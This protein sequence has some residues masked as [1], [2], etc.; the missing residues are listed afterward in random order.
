MR[1]SALTE[2]TNPLWRHTMHF[3]FGYITSRLQGDVTPLLFRPVLIAAVAALAACGSDEDSGRPV[4]IVKT[5]LTCDDSL[6]TGFT[7]DA[8]TTVVAVKSF[9]KGDALLLSGAATPRTP[10]AAN[11]V[12]MV[13][14]N[15]GPGNPG[16]ADA[17]STSP[18][19][20]IEIWLPEKA[21]WNKRVHNFG[22][23]GWAGG[24]AGSANAVWGTNSPWDSAGTAA[25]EGA[26]SSA[27]DT[28]HSDGTGSFAMNPDGTINKVLWTDFVS[29]GIHEQAVKTK[30]LATAYYGSEP[31][32]MYFEGGSTGGRQGLKLAQNYPTHYDGIIANAPGINWS[33][34]LTGGMYPQIVFQRD[35]DGTPL[36]T[37]QQDLVSNAAI[38][39]CDVVGGKH[40]GY[41]LDPS[42]CTYDP[43]TDANVLC[44]DDGGTNATDACVSKTQATAINKIWYGMTNDGS[45]PSPAADNGWGQA[46]TP[47]LPGGAQ[48][49]FGP[50]RGTSLYASFFAQYGIN[51]HANPNGPFHATADQVALELQNPTISDST[52]KNATGDGQSL[53]KLLSYAQLANAF[54]RGLALQAEFG[55]IN[56]DNPDLSAFKNRGGKLLMWHGL[57]DELVMPQGTINYYHRVAVQMGGLSSV[58]DFYRLYLVPGLGH[59]SPNGTS[60][61]AAVPPNFTPT[62]MY[63]LLT[64]W[65]ENGVVPDQVTLQSTVGSVTNSQPVCVY[66]KKATY[67]SGDPTTGTSYVCS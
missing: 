43:T 67:I 30:A 1:A 18:G 58:Q 28:G 17:P 23:G 6:K 36:T 2:S 14:L 11:D 22:G 62:Q 52:F 34:F 66:P 37:E 42:T 13:K 25:R 45:V 20:G 24:S 39:A 7:P 26:V 15:V 27:T 48:R 33:R 8:N 57:A 64:N 12:C 56:T 60:N 29:R 35:L 51:G 10:V 4:A 9:K 65:V 31:K 46:F 55:E 53:W 61:P 5:Q 32:Y 38:A 63:E 41:I 40:L 49:W 19:I 44:T 3:Q 50:T 47:V 59:S 16:P 54:D 21:N